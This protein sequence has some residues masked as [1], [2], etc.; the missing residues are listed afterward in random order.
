[1]NNLKKETGEL[2]ALLEKAVEKQDSAIV[3]KV[4]AGQ[5]KSEIDK[6]TE[7][8]ADVLETS[9]LTNRAAQL[10]QMVKL[11]Q[12][13]GGINAAFNEQPYQAQEAPPVIDEA[14]PVILPAGATV[15]PGSDIE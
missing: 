13:A 14:P 7:Y 11:G 15:S 5:F 6:E 3:T 8:L 4:I 10:R 1:M 12:F 2:G 9:E